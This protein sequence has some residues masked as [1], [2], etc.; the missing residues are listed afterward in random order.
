MRERGGRTQTAATVHQPANG[1]SVSLTRPELERC[2]SL[3]SATVENGDT[4]QRRG[5]Q[6]A[7]AH[8][9]P[10]DHNSDGPEGVLC[11]DVGMCQP[12]GGCSPAKSE[13]RNAATTGRDDRVTDDGR[14][15]RQRESAD[16]AGSVHAVRDGADRLGG[17]ARST[18]RYKTDNGRNEDL[19][20][21][22][23][24]DV[25]PHDVCSEE[26]HPRRSA[27]QGLE[28]R[29]T[30]EHPRA[31]EVQEL[32]GNGDAVHAAHVQGHTAPVPQRGEVAQPR[33]RANATSGL[34]ALAHKMLKANRYAQQPKSDTLGIDFGDMP[35]HV[36]TVDTIRVAAVDSLDVLSPELT[37]R[38]GR[39]Q[40][41]ILG[42]HSDLTSKGRPQEARIT[43][44]ELRRL[45]AAG[46]IEPTAHDEAKGYC[47]LFPTPEPS[48]NRRR[49]IKH[50]KALNT[51]FGRDTLEK[52][53]LVRTQDLPATVFCGDFVVTLDFAA[54]FDQIPLSDRERPFHCFP[55]E[56]KWY[57]LTR[58]PMGQRQA[59]D[60]ASTVTDMLASFQLPEGVHVHT[61]IDNIRFIGGSR[62]SVIA[63][64]GTFVQRA[65]G[66]GA[67]LN[68]ITPDDA[69]TQPFTAVE[70]L[71]AEKGEF[72]GIEFDY[73]AKKVR[74]GAKTI[75]KLRLLQ[76]YFDSENFT[77]QNFIALFGV[78]FFT[79]QVT[80]PPAAKYYHALKEYSRVA[81]MVQCDPAALATHYKGSPS[82]VALIRQWIREVLENPWVDVVP[83][84]TPG[85]C[86][87]TLVTDASAWGWG[88]LLW[89]WEEQRMWETSQKWETRFRANKISTW[90]ETE[91]ITRALRHFFPEGPPASL[92]VLTDSSAAA[93]AFT[94]GR[95]P[96]YALNRA[97]GDAQTAG[98]YNQPIVF[99]HI[100][101]ATNPAD[102]LSRGKE[103]GEEEVNAATEQVFCVV[104]GLPPRG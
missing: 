38:W 93:G 34:S 81:R 3:H 62:A 68:E 69:R 61:Y 17:D 72:L 40:R 20:P 13:R 19:R 46:Q 78:L 32:H 60:V 51:Q 88:A 79:M 91:G 43:E 66:I 94:K 103:M 30:G 101:G 52:V 74:I 54:W 80:R 8:A 47:H 73:V 36:K 48:K 84:V 6:P 22:G 27:G 96:V 97:V 16:I 65:T 98:F 56:G 55:F 83:N 7:D 104:M 57:R 35:L 67:T 87:Y 14:A 26:R 25:Q 99:Q 10:R 59:V 58:L 1:P 28:V 82:R 39:V 9:S 33:G 70:R 24:K 42:D 49:L 95:S 29:A 11:A 15:L 5:G 71:V 53:K 37:A 86:R 89:D 4:T 23:R 18:P 2:V 44:D 45:L 85:D 92:A 63:A 102:M 50:T 31:G 41:W 64:A 12:P 90:A 76:E 21:A 77:V 75:K 100:E